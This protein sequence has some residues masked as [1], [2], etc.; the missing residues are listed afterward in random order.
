MDR[1]GGSCWDEACF[2]GMAGREEKEERGAGGVEIGSW[3]RDPEKDISLWEDGATYNPGLFVNPESISKDRLLG[4][5]LNVVDTVVVVV[6]VV[7]VFVFVV[8]FF[9]VIIIWLLI[10]THIL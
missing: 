2:C 9:V 4:S 5:C 6:V 7:F 10:I 3:D 1:S 8:V